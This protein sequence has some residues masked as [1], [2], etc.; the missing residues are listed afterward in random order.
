MSGNHI[1]AITRARALACRPDFLQSLPVVV[2]DKV[3]GQLGLADLVRLGLGSSWLHS[4][5]FGKAFFWTVIRFDEV[6]AGCAAKVT[7]AALKCLLLRVNAGKACPAPPRP[8]SAGSRPRCFRPRPTFTAALTS[9]PPPFVVS[10]DAG[11]PLPLMPTLMRSYSHHHPPMPNALLFP[12]STN[13]NATPATVTR[14]LS[15]RGCTSVTGAGLLPLQGSLVL[16]RIDLRL[17][18]KHHLTAGPTGLHADFVVPILSSMTDRN[19]VLATIQFRRARVV[20]NFW[21][22]IDEPFASLMQQLHIALY[23]RVK[24]SKTKCGF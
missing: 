2:F 17:G 7:D 13:H 21:Q 15:L 9:A 12:P 10:P 16:E 5:V 19:H 1:G 6:E 3:V 18:P 20:A 14:T 8:V 11:L 4:A 24:D 22:S 23:Y